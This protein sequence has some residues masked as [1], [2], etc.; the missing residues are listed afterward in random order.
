MVL[1]VM[2]GLIEYGSRTA[3]RDI[4]YLHFCDS[5][6]QEELD[7]LVAV[8]VAMVQGP[9]LLLGVV[10]TLKGLVMGDLKYTNSE[11]V[12]ILLG[13][14]SAQDCKKMVDLN[15]QQAVC[16]G[17]HEAEWGTGDLVRDAWG[18]RLRSSRGWRRGREGSLSRSSC[19]GRL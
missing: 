10:A 2:L 1:E 4:F 15:Q 12:L 6:S 17:G 19:P 8:I 5:S 14:E 3:K 11:D 16:E 7:S 13:K 18:G 9:R